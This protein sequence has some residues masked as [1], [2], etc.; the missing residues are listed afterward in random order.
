MKQIDALH[1]EA[2]DDLAEGLKAA[3]SGTQ[4][5]GQAAAPPTD[6][7]DLLAA[8]Y[9]KIRWTMP[10]GRART[11]AMSEVVEEMLLQLDGARNFDV[12]SHLESPDRGLRLAA[13]AYLYANPDP[14]WVRPLARQ[15][16][17]EDKPYNEYWALKALRRVLRGHC[18]QLDQETRDLLRNRMNQMP[19]GTDRAEQI[20]TLLSECPEQRGGQHAL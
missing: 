13:A 11:R 8:K 12:K 4:S 19:P 20:R 6:P 2:T 3:L 5:A 18:D 17:R 14:A 15:A 7:V 16:V 9:N 1:R 10:S